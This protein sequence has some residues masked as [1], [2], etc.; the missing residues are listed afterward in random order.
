MAIFP[1]NQFLH[2]APASSPTRTHCPRTYDTD[3][4]HDDTLKSRNDNNAQINP[5]NYSS[6]PFMTEYENLLS[7]SGHNYD[8]DPISILDTINNTIDHPVNRRSSNVSVS[9]ME[10]DAITITTNQSSYNYGTQEKFPIL[11]ETCDIIEEYDS[12]TKSISSNLTP[13]ST[14][15]V[16]TLIETI[17]DDFVTQEKQH[18]NQIRYEEN[19]TSRDKQVVSVSSNLHQQSSFA[20]THTKDQN[21]NREEESLPTH[22]HDFSNSNPDKEDSKKNEIIPIYP[23]LKNK[24]PTKQLGVSKKRKHTASIQ[25]E[26]SS[27]E[28]ASAPLNRAA[29]INFLLDRKFDAA[30]WDNI[31]VVYNENGKATMTLFGLDFYAVNV[32]KLKRLM[33]IL[34]IKGRKKFQKTKDDMIGCIYDQWKQRNSERMQ[35]TASDSEGD[36][37]NLSSKKI[38]DDELK[39]L[40]DQGKPTETDLGVISPTQPPLPTAITINNDLGEGSRAQSSALSNTTMIHIA[41]LEPSSKI[42]ME[43]GSNDDNND[44]VSSHPHDVSDVSTTGIKSAFSTSSNDITSPVNDKQM[45]QQRT[46]ESHL[47]TASQ[48]SASINTLTLSQINSSDLSN[49]EKKNLIRKA[50]ERFEAESQRA[51]KKLKLE[52]EKLRIERQKEKREQARYRSDMLEIYTSKISELRKR[53][54][55]E[56]FDHIE[57]KQ[58]I[59]DLLEYYVNARKRLMEDNFDMELV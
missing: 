55:E 39:L 29:R 21:K 50:E 15:G 9:T 2:S 17:F 7:T 49:E 30:T 58:E 51:A 37:Q 28:I 10:P 6:T 46:I 12:T 36:N 57:D 53:K 16:E 19:E 13:V 45:Q 33:G 43:G 3:D 1:S 5:T 59:L 40:N 44:V 22:G 56:N 18:P 32:T 38:C 24:E 54:S 52:E 23:S 11:K 27:H 48:L 8:C 25:E 35:A 20:S 31:N 34:D 47:S 42:A 14:G 26:L 41:E 4:H